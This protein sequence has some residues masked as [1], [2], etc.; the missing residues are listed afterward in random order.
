MGGRQKDEQQEGDQYMSVYGAAKRLG[1]ATKTVL[2]RVV[3]GDLDGQQVAGRI[4]VT[5]ASV[6]RLR[7]QRKDAHKN[8]A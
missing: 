6:E 4:V 2:T 1:I 7:K 5:R 8:V 3:A